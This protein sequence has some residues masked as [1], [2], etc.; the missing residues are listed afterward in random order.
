MAKL[1]IS[2]GTIPNDGTGDSLLAAGVKINSNFNE[3]YTLLGD[4]SSL[5]SGIVT[6]ISAGTGITIS[7]NTGSVVIQVEPSISGAAG[8]WVTTTVGI[9][10]LKNVG[11][12]TT[13]PT[14]R[15]VVNGGNAYFSDYIGIGTLPSHPLHIRSNQSS[16]TDPSV[17]VSPFSTTRPASFRLTNGSQSNFIFGL[18]NSSGNGDLSGL[19]AYSGVVGLSSN[20]PLIFVTNSIEGF[21]LSEDGNLGLNRNSPTSKLDVFG[22]A[23]IS[24]VVTAA[25]F[26]GSGVGLTG[27]SANY[28]NIA[29]VAT[30]SGVSGV[31]S[32]ID[33][34]NTNGLTTIYYP[35][36]VEN[37]TTGQ[38]LRADVDLTYRTD[39]NTLTVP[40]LTSTNISISAGLNVVGISTLGAGSTVSGTTFTSQLSVSGVSTFG[41]RIDASSSGILFDSNSYTGSDTPLQ[42]WIGNS[43]GSRYFTLR[44]SN[45]GQ[46]T[47][48]NAYPTTGHNDHRAP[49]HS[50]TQTGS[51][52]Y[53]LFNNGSVK[54]YHPASS[55]GILDQKF[56]TLGAG[57][58]V[59]GTTFTNQLS[60]SGVSTLGVTSTTSLTAQQL[61]VSGVS[62]VGILTATSLYGD[63]SYT[64]SGKWT[65]TGDGY[66]FI[67]VGVGLSVATNDPVM[68]FA[69]GCTY[70]IV[71]NDGDHPFQIREQ[72]NGFA[73]NNGVVGNGGTMTTIK[74][75]V[76]LDA[77]NTLYYQCPDHAGMGNTIRI[78]PDR[79]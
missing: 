75:T 54:L 53:A 49:T 65:V 79:I 37:R 3:L 9:H 18:Q 72:E 46:V 19:P 73:Y 14:Q 12:G 45:G 34:T 21:R 24:G 69:R 1:G 22:D 6:S 59:T 62:T 57:V 30:Y 50:F 33:I 2:T 4:G 27:V 23:R 67:F 77:P 63:A 5:T 43:G 31:S 29:G 20:N 17:V 16:A 78:Y 38:T 10:T 70:H 28:T 32:S 26:V 76:P 42:L 71:N 60:V 47:F 66:S 11:I 41:S 7:G 35:T 44:R 48:D 15:L 8:T 25:A 74:F 40:N 52:Y 55:S 51:E 13:N 58:T 56:E 68:Y 61:S 64:V 36:F 39:T